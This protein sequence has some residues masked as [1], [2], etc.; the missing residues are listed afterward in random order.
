MLCAGDGVYVKTMQIERW[1]VAYTNDILQIGCQRHAIEKWR[2]WS[3]PAGLVWV[4]QMDDNAEEWAM[5]HL[6]LII[7]MIDASPVVAS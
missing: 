4:G 3:T 2:K 5:K 1:N 6:H 7:A